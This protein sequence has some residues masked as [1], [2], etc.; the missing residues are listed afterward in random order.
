MEKILSKNV[1]YFLYNHKIPKDFSYFIQSFLI[2][3]LHIENKM[4]EERPKELQEKIE[5]YGRTY[6]I[7]EVL[8][9][10]AEYIKFIVL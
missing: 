1:N 3:E 6:P 7:H 5:I 8:F 4:E 10:L 2:T 9:T